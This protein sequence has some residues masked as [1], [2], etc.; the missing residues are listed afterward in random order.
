MTIG[1]NMKIILI[2]DYD[3]DWFLFEGCVIHNCKELKKHFKGIFTSMWGS[4]TV[5]IPKEY[6][7]IIK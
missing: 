4:Y 2:K 3:E 7:E 6:C 5:K 1:N